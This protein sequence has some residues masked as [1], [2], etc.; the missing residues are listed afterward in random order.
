[1]EV[2]V[3]ARAGSWGGGGGSSLLFVLKKRDLHYALKKNRNNL[4]HQI[5][6]N[7]SSY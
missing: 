1:M 2:E 3:G 4:N 6:R 7:E 5:I